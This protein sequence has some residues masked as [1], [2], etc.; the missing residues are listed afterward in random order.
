MQHRSYLI[1]PPVPSQLTQ[2]SRRANGNK[3]RERDRQTD[4]Q[5]GHIGTEK[6]A[7]PKKFIHVRRRQ[8]VAFGF[9]VSPESEYIHTN[10][11]PPLE[12]RW[13]M[14]PLY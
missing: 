14:N 5:T 12:A 1:D 9:S 6:L 8:G 11:Q 7:Y 13:P 3:T 2:M 10:T 4:R